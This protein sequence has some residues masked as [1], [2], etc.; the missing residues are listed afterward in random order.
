M[1]RITNVDENVLTLDLGDRV[2]VK[3]MRSH[4]LGSQAKPSDET[5]SKDEKK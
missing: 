5:S 4:I 3:V 2:R 1:G